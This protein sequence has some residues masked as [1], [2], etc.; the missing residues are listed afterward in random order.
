M[1]V[2]RHIALALLLS[3]CSCSYDWDS[4][5][6]VNVAGGGLGGT[7]GSTGGSGGTGATGGAGGQAGSTGGSAGSTGGSAGS[8]G[9][10]A[11]STGGSAGSTGGSAGSTGGSAGSGS[12]PCVSIN[13][14]FQPEGEP[15][16]S[17]YSADVGDVFGVRDNG[18]EFGWDQ[19]TSG[20]TRVR[21]VDTDARLDTLTHLQLGGDVTWEL[22]VPDGNY[23]VT[24]VAGDPS[25][26]DSVYAIEVE[27][28]LIVEGTPK[29]SQHFIEG[30]GTVQVQ[31]GRLTVSNAPAS[32]NNKL[33]YL[34]VRP[35]P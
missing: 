16:P 34:V 31:D 10:S 13:I 12:D 18:C 8:T 14:N 4:L 27:G 11:G 9:G 2:G 7:S 22:A 17:G 6:P 3:F 24:L 30:S 21:G 25:H 35:A 1:P 15:V 23:D 19:D 20:R 33:C 26:I 32:D 29:Q 5:E 28:D